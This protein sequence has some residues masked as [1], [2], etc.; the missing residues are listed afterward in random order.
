MFLWKIFN[1]VDGYSCLII[2]V[3]AKQRKSSVATMNNLYRNITSIKQQFV[4]LRFNLTKWFL[5]FD[6][7]MWLIEVGGDKFLISSFAIY[8]YLNCIWRTCP[9]KTSYIFIF[10]WIFSKLDLGE[11]TAFK[12][13]NCKYLNK[14]IKYQTCGDHGNGAKQVIY[15]Q[16]K[17]A[18]CFSVSLRLFL[19]AQTDTKS[20]SILFNYTFIENVLRYNFIFGGLVV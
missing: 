18:L 12:K 5:P 8:V 20:K 17:T 15:F 2:G 16:N 14:N 4:I 7:V 9:I 3:G 6:V 13:Q 19:C 11:V 10:I 1:L